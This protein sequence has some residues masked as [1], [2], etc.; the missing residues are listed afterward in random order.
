MKVYRGIVEDNMDLNRR[1]TVTAHIPEL[2]EV[3]S[4]EY[5]SPLMNM[6]AGFFAPPTPA[7]EILILYL[8][9]AG[10]KEGGYYYL[11]SLSSRRFLSDFIE[12]SIF[13][14]EDWISDIGGG[15]KVSLPGPARPEGS[16]SVRFPSLPPEFHN[17]Y[18]N[19]VTP[20]KMGMVSKSSGGIV[21][22]DQKRGG[23]SD[24][25]MNIRT[26]LQSGRKRIDLIDTPAQDQ[27]IISTGKD[28][29]QIEDRIVLAGRQDGEG[30]EASTLQSGEFRVE[31]RGPSKIISKRNGIELKTGA[32]GLN[33]NIVNNSD[34][35]L[36]SKPDAR[37]MTGLGGGDAELRLSDEIE[38]DW[39]GQQITVPT[40]E[41]DALRDKWKIPLPLASTFSAG[42]TH[43]DL[44]K[45]LPE[46]FNPL[47]KANEDWGC[48]NIKSK[49]NN[50]NLETEAVD[51]V[52]HINAPGPLTK[53]VV[54]TGGTV[55]IIATGK[56]SLTSN[57]KIE[58]NA[59]HVD[60]NTPTAHPMAPGELGRVDID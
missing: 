5:M 25:W 2:D 31:S 47:D 30:A 9:T 15:K 42:Q 45:T 19:E 24:A 51:G 17:A 28:Q 60:I 56:I 27:I 37:R 44:A 50:I 3:V 26:R 13:E 38:E 11:G 16:S 41:G 4:V 29:N 20:S 6:D 1:G 54:T 10:G 32:A 58:L 36:A 35:F 8:E 57:T 52:I 49:W 40:I 53:V 48:V 55:D 59:P 18:A 34:G 22:T 33:I 21:M 46:G 39:Q 23:D 12:S 14:G 7:S 43:P